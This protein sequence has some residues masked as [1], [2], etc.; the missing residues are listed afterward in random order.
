MLQLTPNECRVL[1]VLVEKAQ[2]VP[3]QY[4]MTVNSIVLGANQKNNRDPVTNL[5]EEDVYEALD[6]LRAKGLVREAMLSGSRVSKFR[7][8]AREVLGVDTE[9]LVVLTELLLRGPQ[10]PGELRSRAS[11]MH[12]LESVEKVEQILRNLMRPR[13]ASGDTPAREPLVRE[14][15]RRPGERANRYVQ[16]LC[17]DLHPLDGPIAASHE[18]A[19]TP[20]GAAPPA[21]SELAARVDEL[22]AEVRRLRA[23]V[24]RLAA[25]MGESDPLEGE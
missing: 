8:L 10:S 13:E 14:L 16:L 4:P 11:R 20:A 7:H 24:R 3:A 9:E 19:G 2:T 6:S 21:S 17:P 25:A 23:A 1:G 5:S 15:P 22:E 12:P 18:H